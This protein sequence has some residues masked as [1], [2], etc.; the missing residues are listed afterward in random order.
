M[1]GMI[2]TNSFLGAL[3]LSFIYLLNGL[4]IKRLKFII[5]VHDVSQLTYKVTDLKDTAEYVAVLSLKH[6]ETLY[7]EY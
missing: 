5:N 7:H 6:L 4:E 1:V 3:R 2:L